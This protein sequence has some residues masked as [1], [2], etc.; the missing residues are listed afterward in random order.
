MRISLRAARGL[1]LSLLLLPLAAQAQLRWLDGQHF[2]TLPVAVPPSVPASA[3]LSFTARL[4]PALSVPAT[5]VMSALVV[6]LV[7]VMLML[8]TTFNDMLHIAQL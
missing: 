4:P 1:V 6:M 5:D 7:V 2:K 8:F 3:V